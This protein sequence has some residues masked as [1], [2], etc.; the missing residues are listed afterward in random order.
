M[1][2]D[3]VRPAVLLPPLEPGD[4]LTISPV[5]AYNV[6]QW[7]QFIRLRPAVVLVGRDGSVDMIRRPET[8]EDI[9]GPE[10]LPE[11]LRAD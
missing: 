1:N 5:G 3:V 8:V 2:I 6:T 4:V 11:R 10:I 9:K 7:M